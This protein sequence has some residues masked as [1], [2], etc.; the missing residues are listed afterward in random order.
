MRKLLVMNAMTSIVTVYIGIFV[1]L[2]IWQDGRK[3]SEVSLYNMAMFLSWGLA[4]FTA[5]KLLSRWSIRVPLGISAICGAAAFAYL[6]TVE[7]DNR[8]LWIVLLG[9]PVGF[10]FGF[11]QAAQSLGIA[12]RGKSSEFAPYFAAVNI[13]GQVLS[14]VIPVVSAQVIDGFGYGGS[15]AMMLVCLALMLFFSLRM[16]RI[17]LVK[18]DDPQEAETFGRF[19]FRQA[20]G[21]PGSRWIGLSLLAA[22]VFMQFQ[23]LFALLFTFSITQNKLWI[24]LLNV[25][26]TVCSLIG[27]W[28][29]RRI[30]SSEM[31]WLWLGNGLL[32]VGFLLALLRAPAALIASNVL[33]TVGMLYFLTVWSA[34]QFRFVQQLGV[35]SQTSFLVWRECTLVATRCILLLLTMSLTEL[36]GVWFVSIIAITI[37]CMLLVPWFQHKA[38]KVLDSLEQ[39]RNKSKI[40]E[41]PYPVKS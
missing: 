29:Y 26:Y 28:L 24:A 4:F 19:G 14:I 31:R 39:E 13:V 1:N 27:L 8:V 30:R 37:V 40:K 15:F 6:M 17:Q 5:A 33:T 7:L 3:I 2:Y 12:Q 9:I 32:A 35:S 16:P 36:S 10:L 41:T 20:F 18:P 21:H 38:M 11:A 22:G 25:I 23:N 34:Q